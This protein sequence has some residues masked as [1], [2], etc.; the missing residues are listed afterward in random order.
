MDNK[1][2]GR[3]IPVGEYN[4]WAKPFFVLTKEPSDY[5]APA[6]KGIMAD[7]EE[8]HVVEDAW[9]FESV[10]WDGEGLP[11]VGCEC[12]ARY[13]HMD[14]ANW[15]HFR[16]I[17]VDGGVAFGW[18]AG[19]GGQ[20]ATT[21]SIKG[22]EFRPIRSEADKKRENL[23]KALHIAAGAAP[24]EVV[25][26]GPLYLELADKIIAGEVAGIRID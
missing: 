26:I 17:G 10:S 9:K 25:G 3:F 22:Y 8:Y 14:K 2:I 15:F 11:P 5:L 4:D 6:W 1:I 7:G 13:R 19:S 23:A 16:C 12:E 18:S 21:L 24:I 20:A